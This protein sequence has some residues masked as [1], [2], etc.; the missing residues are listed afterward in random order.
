METGHIE[1]QNEC[2]RLY[3]VKH[4]IGKFEWFY[5]AAAIQSMWN[6][7]AI[8]NAENERK[9]N[10]VSNSDTKPMYLMKKA[11]LRMVKTFLQKKIGT[12]IQKMKK[13]LQGK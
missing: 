9:K 3:D 10:S 13:N 7:V 4:L 5:L 11:W 12:K 6:A 8:E 2:I 1:F